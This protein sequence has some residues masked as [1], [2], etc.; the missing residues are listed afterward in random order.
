M[1]LKRGVS[2]LALIL[3]PFL[4]HHV[5]S[6]AS[7]TTGSQLKEADLQP[8]SWLTEGFP[9]VLATRALDLV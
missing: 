9:P 6:R 4:T 3:V 8:L 2:V 5:C 7:T 1:G